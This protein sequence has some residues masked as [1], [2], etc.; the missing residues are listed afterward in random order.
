MQRGLPRPAAL[1]LLPQPRP[2]GELVSLQPAEL[3][4]ELLARELA[5][6]L[7][8]EAAKFPAREGR[9]GDKV[10]W[11]GGARAVREGERGG[12]APGPCAAGAAPVRGCLPCAGVHRTAR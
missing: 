2:D 8:F 3:A 9:K 11:D 4:R 1:D 10:G 5:A 6:L 12:P 7:G